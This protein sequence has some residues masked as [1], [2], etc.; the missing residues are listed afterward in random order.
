[1]GPA[2]I[3]HHPPKSRASMGGAGTATSPRVV[4]TQPNTKYTFKITVSPNKPPAVSPGVVSPTFEATNLLSLPSDHHFVEPEPHHL[5]D[6]LSAHRER[7]SEP[8][9]L[10][11]GSDDAAYTQ[12]KT[13]SG[14]LKSQPSAALLCRQSRSVTRKYRHSPTNTHPDTVSCAIG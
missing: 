7:P 6:P 13:G 9:R 4:V 10:S 8:R 11:M 2:Y 3:H 5:S 12:G 14:L 1:M